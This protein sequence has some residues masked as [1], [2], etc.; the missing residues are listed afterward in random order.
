MKNMVTSL[1]TQITDLQSNISELEL[2]IQNLE[3]EIEQKDAKIAELESTILT[4]KQR[5][6]ELERGQTE[7]P[8]TLSAGLY[9]TG[10]T[11]LTKSWE[12]LVADGDIT[13]T[14]NGTNSLECVNKDIAGDLIL[15][16]IEGLN[17]LGGAF[18][19]CKNLTKIDFRNLDTSQVYSMF[20]LFSDCSSLTT[21]DLSML[22][23]EN[24]K[25]ACGMFSGCLS[26]QSLDISNFNTSNVTD[27]GSMFQGCSAL[28]NLDTCVSILNTSKVTN[29]SN[30]FAQCRNLTSLNLSTFDTTLVTNMSFMFSTCE[31]L[32]SIDLSSFNTTNVTDMA[33]MFCYC[34]SL[35]SISLNNFDTNNVTNM[36]NMFD[37]CEKLSS[38]NLSNFN[39]TKV[40]DMSNMFT[41]TAIRTL[42]LSSFDT[43]L[44]TSMIGMFQNCT[45]LSSL[46]ISSFNTSNVENMAEM[47]HDCTALSSLDISTF[48]CSKVY[49]I[50]SFLSGMKLSTLKLPTFENFN[51]GTVTHPA[52]LYFTPETSSCN[53]TYPGTIAEW[54][55]KLLTYESTGLPNDLTIH[56]SDGDYVTGSVEEPEQYTTEILSTTLNL[57]KSEL[58]S[59]KTITS[60]SQ[61]LYV[62]DLGQLSMDPGVGYLDGIDVKISFLNSNNEEEFSV[63]ST[64]Q[65][66]HLYYND[67]SAEGA[68][69]CTGF[70]INGATS[71]NGG[72]TENK[73]MFLY[74][75]YTEDG[76][77]FRNSENNKSYLI[78]SE[79]LCVGSITSLKIYK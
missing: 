62:I 43:S 10:T 34:K 42:S 64:F 9:E 60:D 76:Q 32:T 29:M 30:M 45:K 68:D 75:A 37:H 79:N 12:Q 44:V 69:P 31:N 74:E 27:M 63:L 36:S 33:Y 8:T 6:E 55:S 4:L 56:C 40:T 15:P 72:S 26:L 24:L 19:G 22:N 25:N 13:V 71:Y 17:F 53:I 52:M 70:I 18:S 67:G 58:S 3:T 57:D 49:N 54:K 11:T 48:D 1:N 65:N 51:I 46:S 14:N 78:L 59:A 38:L 47:F 20:D 35:T 73:V 39:T 21:L 5:I 41:S 28:E 61:T 16:K 50:S 2:R 23:T 77:T 7:D 66:I